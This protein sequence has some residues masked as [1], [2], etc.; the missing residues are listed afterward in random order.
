MRTLWTARRAAL[1]VAGIAFVV[2]CWNNSAGL[3]FAVGID[4]PAVVDR[5]LR[6]LQTNDWHPHFF[7]YPS[8]TFYLHAAV[9]TGSYL[10][11]ASAGK[12]T[13]LATFDPAALYFSARLAT[14]AIGAWTVWLVYRIGEELESPPLGLVA[15]AL[16]AVH[17]LHVRESHFALAD[18]PV[19]ALTTLAV[20]LSCRAA[21]LRSV[22]SFAWAGLT[23]GLAASAKY[24]GAVAAL[25]VVAAW[26]LGPS[27]AEHRRSTLLAALG[28]MLTGFVVAS[29][30]AVLDISHFL[31][32]F[33]S[34][35]GRFVPRNRTA[36]LQPWLVY[37][38]HLR[39]PTPLWLPMAVAG[40]V[41]VAIRPPSLRRWLPLLA[42]SAGYFYVLATHP[43]IFARYALPIVP[44][45]CLFA[46][47][48]AVRLAGIGKTWVPG[49]PSWGRWAAGGLL[50]VALGMMSWGT[51]A[52]VRSAG[53]PDTR[54]LAA[55]WLR[56]ASP[57]G[58]VVAVDS[59]GPQHLQTLGF[60]VVWAEILDGSSLERFLRQGVSYVVLSAENPDGDRPF[61]ERGRVVFD[62][63]AGP[64]RAGPSIRIVS[65]APPS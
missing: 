6:M 65:L 37:L 2:R 4:E 50:A 3:P 22:A 57:A 48:A 47:A 12:W 40:M 39:G 38:K 52:W 25:A 10:L 34:Q 19:T 58:T 56:E 53:R 7:F 11:G 18:V 51:A 9:A 55:Q 43:L 32:D 30:Y 49:F 20:L 59:M 14:A 42:F 15:A 60:T 41:A 33:G 16:L 28:A 31:N 17:S 54:V 63:P 29:P 62:L 45:G 26:A 46:A 23:V 13:S 1:A 5:A 64:S 44:M 21:R 24:N 61:L 36:S 35:A 27:A 8:L